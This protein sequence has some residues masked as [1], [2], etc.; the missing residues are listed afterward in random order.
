MTEHEAKF[1]DVGDGNDDATRKLVDDEVRAALAQYIRDRGDLY[2]GY[3]LGG[4]PTVRFAFATDD[5]DAIPGAHFT[6]DL[7]DLILETL[8]RVRE[9]G[10]STM[11]DLFAALFDAYERWRAERMAS[12]QGCSIPVPELVG[13]VAINRKR[14]E[15]PDDEPVT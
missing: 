12:D 4:S 8:E 7:G 3:R 5:L 2:C 13:G 10:P 11:E 1:W 14:S 15:A 6:R 9:E